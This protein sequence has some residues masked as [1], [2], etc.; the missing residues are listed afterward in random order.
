MF[1][2]S[3]S[4]FE[5]IM[6]AAITAICVSASTSSCIAIMAVFA[7]LVLY[8]TKN[9]AIDVSKVSKTDSP[10]GRTSCRRHDYSP[11]GRTSCRPCRDIRLKFMKIRKNARDA[12]KK[13][14]VSER[15]ASAI[16][17]LI[18]SWGRIDV[19][20]IPEVRDEQ[21]KVINLAKYEAFSSYD[22]DDDDDFMGDDHY[23]H[24]VNYIATKTLAFK[25]EQSCNAII[26]CIELDIARKEEAAKAAEADA[27]A[28]RVAD[29]TDSVEVAKKVK[30][31][32]EHHRMVQ[33]SKGC[34][35]NAKAS[36]RVA[37]DIVSSI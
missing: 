18:K 12:R 23:E 21:T 27:A 17:E 29:N 9:S 28:S 20:G 26:K 36:M 1:S 13:I 31:A 25:I 14:Y 11:E 4:D 7:L 34:L 5:A 10:E 3:F 2:S 8:V 24:D 35:E 33:F 30:V 19:V 22:G 16:T 37:I 15:I 32:N 6:I